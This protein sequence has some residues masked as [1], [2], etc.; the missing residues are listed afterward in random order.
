MRMKKKLPLFLYIL[1]ALLTGCTLAAFLSGALDTAG[2][3]RI[4]EGCE[5]GLSGP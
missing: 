4:L 5:K 3:L 1:L 2:V